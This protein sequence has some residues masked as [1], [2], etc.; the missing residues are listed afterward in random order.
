MKI[1]HLYTTRKEVAEFNA[2]VFEGA[3]MGRKTTVEAI[4]SIA[5]D[6]SS[7]IKEKILSKIP[8]D[9]SKTKGLSKFLNLAEDLPGELSINVDVSDGLTNGTP[10]I[11][12]KL[13][14]RVYASERCSIVWVLFTSSDIGKKCRVQ[15]SHLYNSDIHLLWTPILEVTRKFQYNYYNSFQITRRQF[16]VALASAKTVHKAQGC[17]LSSAVVHL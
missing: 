15:F 12:K 17:T 2:T 16:P 7:E 11:I 6:L 5:G 10:C 8:L 14:Y 3:F 1:P 13:D 9:S 4:D